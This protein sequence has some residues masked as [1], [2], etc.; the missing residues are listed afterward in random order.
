MTWT[1]GSHPFRSSDKTHTKYT[2]TFFRIHYLPTG[3]NDQQKLTLALM[4]EGDSLSYSHSGYS[5]LSYYKILNMVKKTGPAQ[6]AW[7]K[8]SLGTLGDQANK[9]IAEIQSN[10]DAVEEYLYHSCRCALAHA[11]VNPTVDP[12]DVEDSRRLSTDLPLIRSLAKH[13]IETEFGIDPLSKIFAE[14]LY[15]LSGFKEVIDDELLADI[16]TCDA[17]NRRRLVLP[18]PLSI[19]Q[20]CDKRYGVFENLTA[21]TKLIR[22]GVVLLECQSPDGVLTVGLL[23]DF[24]NNQIHFDVENAFIESNAGRKSIEYAIDYNEFFRDLIGNGEIEIYFAHDD[25]FLG[26]KDANLPVNIDLGGTFKL[27]N[28]K[29]DELKMQL[30]ELPG[31]SGEQGRSGGE[32]DSE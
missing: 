17:V 23:L 10:G 2:A 31:Q 5:F 14:H 27:L 1:G 16:L 24:G 11:G 20:W 21:K 18:G 3:L 25:K 9:R 22:D 8:K 15:E 28:A 29:I 30:G 32:A 4:R 7:I 26:R 19:R 12:D 6:K 13:A